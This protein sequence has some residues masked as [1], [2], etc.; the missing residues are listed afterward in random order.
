MADVTDAAFR[1]MLTMY[2]T[3]DVVWTEFVSAN[4]LASAGREALL[5]DLL[6]S[7]KERPIVAQ[8]FTADPEK[9][10]SA[11]K[12]VAERGFDGVDINMGCPDKTIEKQ[13]AGAKM[14]SSPLDA[15][16]VIQA[17]KEGIKAAGKDIPVSVKTRIGFHEPEVDTWIPFLLEQDIAAL[18]VHARTRKELSKVPA[19]WESL[20]EVVLHRDR[21]APH[22]VII[23]NGDVTSL[24]DGRKKAIES[25]VDGVMIGRA[26][27]GNPWFFD[28]SREVVATLPKKQ[29]TWIRKT[30]LRHFFDTKRSAA[31]SAKTPIEL[32]ERLL[33]MMEHTNLFEKLLGSTKPFALMKKHFKAY[34]TGFPGSKELRIRLMEEAKN[35]A[36]VS[37]IVYDFLKN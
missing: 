10:R 6:Y 36:D 4:G 25:G 17:A 32:R 34:C 33:V 13:G 12:L 9:M 3:P 37:R 16:K 14:I 35:A 29:P 30:F 1:Q 20:R 24:S 8:L 2:G 5:I 28:A 19:H 27:F 11:A 21:I 23:G 31:Q 18:T 22:T 15:Q 26:L 7:E